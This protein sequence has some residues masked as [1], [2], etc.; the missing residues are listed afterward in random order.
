MVGRRKCG[1]IAWVK[2]AADSMARETLRE[3]TVNETEEDAGLCT[4]DYE[5]ES[6]ASQMCC[7]SASLVVF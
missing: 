1:R 3:G 2:R 7:T 6:V 5:G 4:S